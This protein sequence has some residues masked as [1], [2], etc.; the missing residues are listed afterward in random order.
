MLLEGYKRDIRMKLEIKKSRFL[1]E[2]LIFYDKIF[3]SI[4]F[5][6]IVPNFF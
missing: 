6:L 1:G 4:K 5:S 2:I 3:Y